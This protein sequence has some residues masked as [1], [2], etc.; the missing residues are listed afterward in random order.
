MSAINP[1]PNVTNRIMDDSLNAIYNIRCDIILI[2][3]LLYSLD[4]QQ[5]KTPYYLAH[6]VFHI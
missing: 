5:H 2:L 4:H 6:T 1:A 3:K